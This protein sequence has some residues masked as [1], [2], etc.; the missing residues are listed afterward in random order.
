MPKIAISAKQ[1]VAILFACG[2]VML[3]QSP[4]SLAYMYRLM[5]ACIL[6]FTHTT[7]AAKN[8]FSR[9][10]E[11]NPNITLNPRRIAHILT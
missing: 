5:R 10:W 1:G 6:C 9:V 4:G 8:A 3:R 11:I 7:V 2:H